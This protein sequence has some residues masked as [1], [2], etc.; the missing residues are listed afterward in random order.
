MDLSFFWAVTLARIYV[1]SQTGRVPRL[2]PTHLP[3]LRPTF[4]YSLHSLTFPFPTER[5]RQ[6]G[7][8]V[9]MR[10]CIYVYTY[11]CVHICLFCMPVCHIDCLLARRLAQVVKKS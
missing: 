9:C 11:I 2:I 3:A 7:D 1:R 8:S 4:L 6:R 5:D 10:E